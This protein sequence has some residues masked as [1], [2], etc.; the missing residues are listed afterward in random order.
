MFWVLLSVDRNRWCH[1][2]VW[3]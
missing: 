2:R 1:R 3:L